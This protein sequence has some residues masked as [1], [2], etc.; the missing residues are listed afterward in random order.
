M[1]KLS[2]RSEEC[3]S[4]KSVGNRKDRNGNGLNGVDW[5]AGEQ[6]SS[7]AYTRLVSILR[8]I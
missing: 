8:D 1:S 6:F 4:C 3:V 2:T 5:P 7:T